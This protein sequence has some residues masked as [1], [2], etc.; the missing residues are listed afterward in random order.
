MRSLLTPSVCGNL[1]TF[2]AIVFMGPFPSSRGNMFFLVAVDYV[3]TGLKRKRS[4]QMMPSSLQN[5]EFLSFARFGASPC[6]KSKDR[7][8]CPACEDSQF[9][10]HQSFT[11]QLQLGIRFPNFRRTDVVCRD[12]SLKKGLGG[13][14]HQKDRK[15]SQNDKTE[16]GMEKMCR[17]RQSPN[18]KV[19]VN[20]EESAVKPGAEREYLLNAILTHLM[21]RESPIVEL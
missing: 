10:H 8:N 19:R 17:I 18:T 1:L 14:Y 7:G 4:P 9:C 12:I 5:S 21:G 20:T 3:S 15:P 11:S 6:K 13:G 16:H 2:W